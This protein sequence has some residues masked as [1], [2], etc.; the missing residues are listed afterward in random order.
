MR[1][2]EIA[3]ET[4]SFVHPWNSNTEMRVAWLGSSMGLARTGVN[5]LTLPAGGA[6]FTYHAHHREEEWIYILSG[7]AVL[8]AGDAQHQLGPGDF[9]TFPAPQQPHQLR[10]T[11]TA[12]VVYL[13]GGERAELDVTEFPKL[14]KRIIRVANQIAVYDLDDTQPPPPFPGIEP[15]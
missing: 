6:S 11:S 3:A 10:N 13:A 5:L 14:N 9:V 1:A 4:T 15:L 7:R 8:D 12:D 2:D